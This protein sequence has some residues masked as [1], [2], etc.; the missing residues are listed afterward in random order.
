MSLSEAERNIIVKFELEKANSTFAQ[1]EIL[2]A[3]GFWDG[4]A[5]RLY[6][7]AFHAVTALMIND[8]HHVR[9]HHGASALF[10]QLYIK[11]GLL[12]TECAQLYSILQTMREKGDY[13]CSFNVTKEIIEPMIAPTKKLI[14][15]IT[16]LINK[17]A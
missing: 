15:D 17:K 13:N 5:N 6:Y 3:S 7:A 11:T 14:D 2:A 9:T 4:A 1:V 10:S 16:L 12:P 8:G